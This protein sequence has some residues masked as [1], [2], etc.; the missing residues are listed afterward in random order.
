ML[1]NSLYGKDE[2]MMVDECVTFFFAGIQVTRNVIQNLLF[3]LIQNPEVRAKL[4]HEVDI[5]Y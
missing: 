3:R 4:K 5:I 2:D 1:N